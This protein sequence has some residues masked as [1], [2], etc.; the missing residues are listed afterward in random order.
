MQM[1][2]DVHLHWAFDA[3]IPF[4]GHKGMHHTK[5]LTVVCCQSAPTPEKIGGGSWLHQMLWPNCGPSSI[6]GASVTVSREMRE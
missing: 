3:M 1:K 6:A 2:S 4:P 5:E